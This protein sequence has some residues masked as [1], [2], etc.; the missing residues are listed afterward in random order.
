MW[1]NASRAYFKLQLAWGTHWLSPARA[2]FG[3]SELRDTVRLAMATTGRL[4]Q[5]NFFLPP[6]MATTRSRG[7]DLFDHKA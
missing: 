2:A 6:D 7:L 1:C 4:R 3:A 5:T